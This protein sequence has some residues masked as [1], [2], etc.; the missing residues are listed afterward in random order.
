MKLRVLVLLVAFAALTGAP[1]LAQVNIS[2]GVK[3]GVNSSD[4]AIDPTEDECCSRKTGFIGGLF[5]TVPFSET[6]GFQPEFLYSMKGAKFEGGFEIE[7]DYFEVPLL[8]R[9][10]FSAATNRGFVLFGPTLGFNRSAKAKFE[11]EEEDIKDDVEN[12]DLGFAIAAGFQFGRGSV[13]A[14]YTHGLSDADTDPDAKARHR[15]VS[16][17][18]GF[19]F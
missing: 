9:A 3:A 5:V 12:F 14:R 16:L 7:A 4:I 8:V 2:G 19:R 6:L 10:D 11:D 13:E 1:A 15:V 18:A 17:L